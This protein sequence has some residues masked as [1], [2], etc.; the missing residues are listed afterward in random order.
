M[1][2]KI[3]VEDILTK[4]LLNAI[5]NMSATEKAEK[6]VQNAEKYLNTDTTL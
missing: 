4:V 2:V 6:F 5:K 1:A 3:V